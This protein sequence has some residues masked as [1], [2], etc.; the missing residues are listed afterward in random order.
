[1]PTPKD[2]VLSLPDLIRYVRVLSEFSRDGVSSKRGS[3]VRRSIKIT[4]FDLEM[5]IEISK[6]SGPTN[7]NTFSANS[8]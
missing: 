3:N 7:S 8:S 2:V 6:F 5:Q 4:K 1:M